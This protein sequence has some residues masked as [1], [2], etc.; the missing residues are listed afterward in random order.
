VGSMKL[1][2]KRIA[3]VWESWLR[4]LVYGRALQ[5]AIMYQHACE[6][7]DELHPGMYEL[8]VVQARAEVKRLTDLNGEAP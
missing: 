7:A 8:E 5:R 6:D 4:R 3:R 2:I 1:S